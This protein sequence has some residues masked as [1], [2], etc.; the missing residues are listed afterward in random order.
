[1]AECKSNPKRFWKYVNRKTKNKDNVSDLKW[2]DDKGNER[3]A[4]TDSD[5]AHA[6]ADFFFCVHGRR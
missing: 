4:E 1:L 3:T 2:Q 5:K 6:V